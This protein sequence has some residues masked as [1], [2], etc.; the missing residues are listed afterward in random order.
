[1][2]A[3]VD[4][5]SGACPGTAHHHVSRAPVN[6][7]YEAWFREILPGAVITVLPGSGDFPHLAQPKALVEILSGWE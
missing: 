3:A 1:M 5:A 6:P 4:E 2:T 7:A